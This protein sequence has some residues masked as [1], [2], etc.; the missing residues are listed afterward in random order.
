MVLYKHG[1]ASVAPQSETASIPMR[2]MQHFK[3]RFKKILVFFDYDN[4]GVKGAEMLCEK[5]DLEK[6]FISKHY[7]EIY[8][9]KDISDFAKEMSE[10]KTIE[11]L[12]ELFD[13]KND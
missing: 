13:G 7:L 1:Y 10:E 5:H 11:L 3:T 2:L 4:G 8:G 12:K 6:V 9:I